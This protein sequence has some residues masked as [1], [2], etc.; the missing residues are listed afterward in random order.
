M[1]ARQ[2][3]MLV[4]PKFF[5]V[6]N[7]NQLTN[8]RCDIQ[9]PENYRRLA[10][11]F[12][13]YAGTVYLGK[14]KNII[15]KLKALAASKSIPSVALDSFYSSINHTS[16]P[17]NHFPYD[18]I[19]FQLFT[20]GIKMLFSIAHRLDSPDI[21][22]EIKNQILTMLGSEL[23]VCAPGCYT[24]IDNAYLK[25]S[26][27]P[28]RNLLD[29]R[30][31]I[32]QQVA[33][34]L[35]GQYN[36]RMLSD[37]F[38]ASNAI[39][40]GNITHYVAAILNKHQH[41]FGLAYN[42]DEF[43]PPID[44]IARFFRQFQE[45]VD[46]QLQLNNV[47]DY[48]IDHKVRYTECL[49]N[50]RQSPSRSAEYVD[51]LR[52]QLDAFGQD[53]EFNVTDLFDQDK[54]ENNEFVASPQARQYLI[55]TLA[56]RF[57][58][59]KFIDISRASQKI[60]LED[61]VELVYFPNYSLEM[62]Y[63]NVANSTRQPLAAYCFDKLKSTGVIP[64][65]LDDQDHTNYLY[66]EIRRQINSDPLSMLIPHFLKE[67]SD[68]VH[69][70][71]LLISNKRYYFFIR[72][73]NIMPE[74]IKT[75]FISY[76][77]ALYRREEVMTAER[78]IYC[79]VESIKAVNFQLS[80]YDQIKS[81]TL[82]VE[83]LVDLIDILLFTVD[84]IR[85]QS[86]LM[87]GP[88]RLKALLS[89]AALSDIYKLMLC[90]KHEL[91]FNLLVNLHYCG[92][93]FSSMKT[94]D[95]LGMFLSA[96]PPENYRDFILYLLG[97]DKLRAIVSNLPLLTR[98]LS[99]TPD[100]G[101]MLL[102]QHIGAAWCLELSGV[103]IV[104]FGS[105]FSY[106]NAT[107]QLELINQWYGDCLNVLFPT[108]I[109]L[110]AFISLF[111]VS[112]K[113]D[114]ILQLPPVCL[115]NICNTPADLLQLMPYVSSSHYKDV[116]SRLGKDRVKRILPDSQMLITFLHGLPAPDYHAFIS[117][118]ASILQAEEFEQYHDGGS[119]NVYDELLQHQ[120]RSTLSQAASY[121]GS[122][123]YQ[124]PRPVPRPASGIIFH[125]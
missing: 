36:R 79:I 56:A 74:D 37:P 16:N 23:D 66:Q 10:S 25:L 15:D 7:R 112:G 17:K 102:V 48:I 94:V 61:D 45:R 106:L 88:E 30:T 52:S 89:N 69:F 68:I 28:E 47:I 91:R 63:V 80:T 53:P 62:S 60:R 40:E 98:L 8:L 4:N 41:Q 26:N 2:Q 44:K 19:S 20:D 77:Q 85:Y 51:Q 87:I 46:R 1:I 118:F 3:D 39:L 121:I 18:A 35:I 96:L 72:M 14:V 34:E 11:F 33:L 97:G 100:N 119:G 22:E 86:L 54:L 75:T 90:F 67:D 83:N 84:S 21:N 55:L 42:P 57:N 99:L 70:Y 9:F 101:R 13:S 59:G 122:L 38:S 117:A 92:N 49:E 64:V 123:F 113:D 93:I 12:Q 81:S 114:F 73:I 82:I 78:L 125:V 6:P 105:I 107:E 43:I 31:E 95:E 116:I 29:V 58:A 111:S 109:H 65:N 5:F 104:N 110:A 108:M 24:I 115:Q 71:M 32:A 76:L 103:N 124:P 27:D 50:I 120:A